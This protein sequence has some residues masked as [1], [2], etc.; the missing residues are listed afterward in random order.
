MKLGLIDL[1]TNS[2][3]FDVYAFSPD[4]SEER[5][6]RER[7]LIR[8]GDTVFT[9]NYI[10]SESM[11]RAI[12]VFAKFKKMGEELGVERYIA[13]GTSALRD[14]KNRE[15]LIMQ[16]QKA[17]GIELR[18][19]SGDEEASLI[20]RGVLENEKIGDEPVAIV[21]IG[22]GS[23][24]II[25]AIGQ[26]IFHATSFNL[27]TLRL[28]QV[29]LKTHPPRP[30]S[31]ESAHPLNELRHHI[32]TSL[33]STIIRGGWPPVKK[34]IGASGTARAI[35]RL[36]KAYGDKAATI[37]VESLEKLIQ[38]MS[39][40]TIQELL[41][42]PGMEAKRVD[43]ILGGAVVLDEVA[44]IFRVRRIH[45]TEFSLRDGLLSVERLKVQ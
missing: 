28:Q 34:V 30:E 9:S 22:G 42:L 38:R 29:Y 17:T 44:E 18:C 19:I 35:T 37:E 33:S 2:I 16:V 12:E 15:D 10:S 23:T 8:L 36:T 7:E 3:R 21:D 6:L 5:L 26:S 20:A 25:V 45:V 24:E 43:I 14:A 41:E 1:G 40:M 31:P 13:V 27:G 4:G 32:R 11:S 39:R